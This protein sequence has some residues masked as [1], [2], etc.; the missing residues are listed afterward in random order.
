MNYKRDEINDFLK[1]KS[2][3]QVDDIL[4]ANVGSEQVHKESELEEKISVFK[5]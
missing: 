4:I 2:L 1:N 3:A 5:G